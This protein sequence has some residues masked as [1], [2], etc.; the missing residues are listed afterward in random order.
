M[1][2]LELHIDNGNPVIIYPKETHQPAS[3]TILSFLWKI[4]SV[5]DHLGANGI[6]F[7]R[8]QGFGHDTREIARSGNAPSIAWFK[9]P[10]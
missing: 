4:E 7:E 9:D 2:L 6:T 10:A 1:E 5:V 8:Y 3:F